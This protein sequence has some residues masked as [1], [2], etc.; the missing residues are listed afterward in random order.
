MAKAKVIPNVD[1]KTATVIFE[2][3]TYYDIPLV[4]ISITPITITIKRAEYPNGV[5]ILDI[6]SLPGNA[7]PI[8]LPVIISSEDSVQIDI[9]SSMGI[10]NGV[11]VLWI[12]PEE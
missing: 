4:L 8:E 2:G 10:P 7:D 9:S 5:V 11:V 12:N 6:D 1:G 3:K